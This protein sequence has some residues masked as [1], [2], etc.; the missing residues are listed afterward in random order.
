MRDSPHTFIEEVPFYANYVELVRMLGRLG[1]DPF[2]SATPYFRISAASVL[3]MGI[4]LL[5][6][7]NVW[8]AAFAGAAQ[9]PTDHDFYGDLRM[10]DCLTVV[11][12]VYN[13]G[14]N[15]R[16]LWA[17]LVSQIRSRFIAFV[18]YDFPEDDT[19]P[20]ARDI[21]ATGENRIRLLQNNKGRGVVGAIL[22]GFNQIEHGPV[23][24]VMA[25]SS[26]DLSRVEEMLNWYWKGYHIVVGSR[27]MKGGGIEGGPWVKQALSRLAGLSLYWLRGLPTHDATNAFK[28]YDRDILRLFPIESRGG[29]EL[30]L[31]LTVKAYL[32]GCAIAEVP[33]CWKDRTYGKSHF[34]LWAWLPRYMRWYLYAFRPR[35]RSRFLRDP[36][37]T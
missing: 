1:I 19:I 37:V 25:D 8:I 3:V 34:K 29:F 28:I 20:V 15:F 35:R 6:T 4:L 24:V 16:T 23:L 10:S 31:E 7:E 18:V 26:D 32:V 22:T 12:P 13:E 9:C 21:V 5:W 36:I 14:A 27:Y 33:C 30:N 11:I 2:K 17:D